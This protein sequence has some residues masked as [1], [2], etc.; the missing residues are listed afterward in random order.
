MTFTNREEAGKALGNELL[1]YA[2]NSIV[3]A[4][5]RGGVP[6]AFEVAKA[7]HAP[8]SLIGVR[9]IG[10]PWNDEFAIGAIA[11]F[12]TILL[13][14]ETIQ[15]QYISKNEI[16]DRIY[17]E[18]NELNRRISLYR[19]GSFPSLKNKTVII[20]DDGLATGLSAKAAII[21]IAKLRPKNIIFAAPV[22]SADTL[23][24][25]LTVVINVVCVIAP[26]DL[27]SIGQ[28]YENFPPVTDK[29]VI[30]LLEA[31]S[32]KMPKHFSKHG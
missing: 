24:N 25:L 31:G 13:D 26:T 22:C 23:Q 18:R 27:Q 14:E 2:Y 16:K 6:V 4:I 9:K 32:Q 19:P 12:H 8:L 21:A 10:S 20:V 17:R 3:C 30:S 29:E 11:E 7:I 1:L 15:E 28:W 5:P